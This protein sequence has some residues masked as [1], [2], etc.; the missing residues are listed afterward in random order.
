MKEKQ[1]TIFETPF[2]ADIGAIYNSG[3][4]D[5][6]KYLFD[7]MIFQGVTET[8]QISYVLATAKHETQ[9]FTSLHEKYN[10][11]S[12]YDYFMAKYSDR[13]DLG[14]RPGTDD[15]YTYY[16]RGFVHLTG[17]A[18]YEKMG[19]QFGVDLLNHPEK[20]EEPLLAAK[21]AVYGML[22]GS[23]TGATLSQY[24]NSDK[25]DYLGAR[26][27]INGIDQNSLIAGYAKD[28]DALL[29]S[30]LPT[31]TI[32]YTWDMRTDN[33][34]N[35]LIKGG[36]ANDTL[37]G[38][39]GDDKLYGGKGDDYL[40]GGDGIDYLYGGPGKNTLVGGEKGDVIANFGGQDSIYGGAGDDHFGVYGKGTIKD[41]ERD[42]HVYVDNIQ[43][44]GGIKPLGFDVP[45]ALNTK[46]GHVFQVTGGDI[47]QENG[48]TLNIKFLWDNDAVATIENYTR[49][50]LQQGDG[51]IEIYQM[52]HGSSTPLAS[53]LKAYNDAYNNTTNSSNGSSSAGGASAAAPSGASNSANS[54]AEVYK[55][56]VGTVQLRASVDGAFD[57]L[58]GSGALAKWQQ[59]LPTLLGL[60]DYVLHTIPQTEDFFGNAISTP[61]NIVGMSDTQLLTDI[62]EEA[63]GRTLPLTMAQLT[64]GITS[65]ADA[66]KTLQPIIIAAGNQSVTGNTL[67]TPYIITG[68]NA[69]VTDAKGSD[70]YIVDPGFGSLTIKDSSGGT[71]TNII[72]AAYNQTNVQT[73]T[74]R[75]THLTAD[76]ASI[77]RDG[78]DLL[79]REVGTSNLVRVKD[80][81]A[82]EAGSSLLFS[83]SADHAVEQIVFADGATKTTIDIRRAVTEAQATDGNDHIIGTV[84]PD[85]LQG[86]KGADTLEGG[87]G[88]DMYKFNAG[89]G[90]DLIRDHQQDVFLDSNDSV[91]FGAG[92]SLDNAVFTRVDVSAS[93]Q[94]TAN[95]EGKGLLI[96]FGGGDK[97]V[98]DSQFDVSTLGYGTFDAYSF[99]PQA[100]LN[101]PLSQ[102]ASVT[103]IP[104][105]FDSTGYT[106]QSGIHIVTNTVTGGYDVTV[107]DINY[108]YTTP[109]NPQAGGL[110]IPAPDDRIETFIFFG[111][112]TALSAEEVQQLMVDRAKTDGNDH[113]AGFAES[114]TLD[115]GAGNDTLEGGDDGDTYL[116]GLGYGQDTVHDS[117]TNVLM[118]APDTVEFGDGIT[119]A[120]IHA[121]RAAGSDD[122]VFRIDGVSDTLTIKNQFAS[123]TLGLDSFYSLNERIE[124]FQFAGGTSWNASDIQTRLL[125]KTAGNDLLQGFF[126]KDVL[127][128]G[129]GNDTLMGGD[130]GDTYIFAK[131]YGNDVI[132][133]RMTSILFKD[134]DR[135]A[136][137]PGITK[138]NVSFARGTDQ[139]DLVVTLNDTGEAVTIKNQFDYEPFEPESIFSIN[140]AIEEFYFSDGSAYTYQDIWNLLLKSTPGDDH[141]IGFFRNDTLDGGAGND[142]LEGGTMSDTYIYATGYGNDTIRD[143]DSGITSDDNDKVQFTNLT[144]AQVTFAEGADR[145]DLVVK[146]IATG[147]TLTIIDQNL[148]FNVGGPP[149]QIE[150]FMFSDQTLSAAEVRTA[151]TASQGTT[152]NDTI[153]GSFGN[154]T[155][156]GGA[157]NDR[158]E[159]GDGADTYVFGKGYGQ[160]TIYDVENEV[161]LAGNDRILFNSS[162]TPADVTLARNANPFD[163]V[164]KLSSGDSI[165]V[166]DHH[167]IFNIGAPPFEMATIEFSDGTVWNTDMI[168]S[169]LLQATAGNDTIT[170]FF[171]N[172]TLIG[173]KGNDLLDGGDGSDTYIYNTGDGVD[174]IAEHLAN[175]FYDT[176]DTLQF[177]AGITEASISLSKSSLSST[178][179]TVKI[180]NVAAVVIKDQFSD[181]NH[182]EQIKF[183]SGVVWDDE[184]VLARLTGGTAGNDTISGSTVVNT[185]AGG[186]GNDVLEF[187]DT[188]NQHYTQH[189]LGGTG[190]DTYFYGSGYG[191]TF[192]SDS[193]GSDTLKFNSGITL[194]SLTYEQSRNDLVIHVGTSA[195][196]SIRIE[197]YF[198]AG[199]GHRVESLNVAGT[200]TSLNALLST[201]TNGNDNLLGTA[202]ADVMTGG[203]GNDTLDGAG[204]RDTL[205]GGPGNDRLIGGAPSLYE[206]V[207]DVYIFN[208]GYGNDTIYDVQQHLYYSTMDTIQLGAGITPN[209]V[210]VMRDG[211]D[212][213]LRISATDTL[214]VESQF[215]VLGYNA[216]E[217][218]QFADGT[219]WGMQELRQ[220]AQTVTDGNDLIGTYHN[221]N[222]SVHAGAGNDTVL[223][224]SGDDAIF[225]DAGDD[226][227]NYRSGLY[228]GYCTLDG[229]DGNDTITGSGSS[230]LIYGGNGNDS[231]T[232]GIGDYDTLQGGNGNDTLDNDSGFFDKL[233]GGD[234]NDLIRAEIGASLRAGTTAYA[235]TVD[236]GLG[237]DTVSFHNSG[238]TSLVVNL[239]AGT[240]TV[241]YDYNT[242][243][244]TV[245]APFLNV[246]NVSIS[247]GT[248]TMIGSAANN[249]LIGASG[250][251]S[252]SG[253]DGNDTL[254]GG[255]GVDT[256][257]GGNGIDLVDYRD[258]SG[259]WN[260]NLLTDKAVYSSITENITNIES[261]FG[262][263]GNDTLTGDAGGNFLGGADGNDF[264]AGGDG[265][266]T[267]MGGAGRD[268]LN[269][270]NGTDMAD[271]GDATVGWNIS[272]SAGTAV[273]AGVTETLT[274]IESVNGSV[275]NDTITGDA[276]ANLLLGN[277]GDDLLT[278]GI[279]RDTMTG[280]D[281]ADIFI[282]SALTHSPDAT[283]DIITDFQP[284]IDKIDLRGLGLT[285]FDTD[286]GLT[287]AGE[288]RLA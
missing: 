118:K 248:V 123:S 178:D 152:G 53:L 259:N 261:A 199:N 215:D 110:V 221:I 33:A 92:L 49:P 202:G 34:T 97:M 98:I 236:G 154:D 119:T 247:S 187:A 163:L 40:D 262:S 175:V 107:D 4:N 101:N 130:M 124:S 51:H 5:Y 211:D 209:A 161:F 252:L 82:H 79:I 254:Q 220:H 159:G 223:G 153:H 10:G 96:D 9:G 62:V 243:H 16:G 189:L 150:Q 24:I 194:S 120:N 102:L 50:Y 198:D 281:G 149:Y 253:G 6:I 69:T 260:I 8:N 61:I 67:D 90:A 166:Q 162:V 11:N 21:I 81:F 114:E 95:L 174:T 127:D 133:D 267:L 87:D 74:I 205:D 269:G 47:L 213:V 244:Y 30:K 196:D 212:M 277:T 93:G 164:V 287:E 122:L 43:V 258:Q 171:T 179:L 186:A 108:H 271:Y 272:L 170:G 129:A 14:N 128:G 203:L 12:A 284:G 185:I 225:G 60:K 232:G 138:T 17:R 35:D 25:A 226:F 68:S 41:I 183:A 234:G 168:R 1:V 204:G 64:A 2:I 167:K 245:T 18:N 233:Y 250:N 58:S 217:V 279:G 147:E 65:D 78:N 169:K 39:K 77:T 242:E 125:Q 136:F 249:Q 3:H 210:T 282:F 274:L 231:I 111:D 200:T 44:T 263:K 172:D 280:G 88:G 265:N 192:I 195:N 158:L 256:M 103:Q 134:N 13:T 184:A 137:G 15:G 273:S 89:D 207:N 191:P 84:D 142:L 151:I 139:D 55:P 197:G 100:I 270:G 143:L 56:T 85:I 216:V 19:N 23:F 86:K 94:A 113:I 52:G 135:L 278:G 227:I 286:G 214:R 22:H 229:G 155:L 76:H 54:S 285:G 126:S 32:P 42:D 117:M 237:N 228:T 80:D 235:N 240:L 73:D 36:N 283:P 104:P 177:G 230:V 165:T 59:Y 241:N 264:L 182:V 239:A 268:T 27:I 251:D 28:Y 156:D 180:N 141:L 31:R 116:F 201:S 106:N 257:D 193:A 188:A 20:A 276:G 208:I 132:D 7:E 255:I 266:D 70:T 109:A 26:A 46:T 45:I 99:V 157:G 148:T 190:N 83:S 121:T 222:D 146:I 160:D 246:E 140:N 37:Y 66:S 38:G 72:A 181:Y 173:G 112:G 115:G 218:V 48:A 75:F 63:Y 91:K 105:G 145:N 219:V 29:E 57:T 131:G 224:S 71:Y 238:A 144:R 288:L 206:T 176:P 275:G